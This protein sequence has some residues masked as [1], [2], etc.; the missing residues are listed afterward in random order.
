VWLACEVHRVSLGE[1]LEARGF[2]RD[3]LPAGSE[4]A[5]PR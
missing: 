1:F 2:L 4:D 5:Q 3:V